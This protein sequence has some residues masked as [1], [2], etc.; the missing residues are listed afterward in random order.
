MNYKC[1][2][3]TNSLGNNE[4]FVVCEMMFGMRESFT[5]FRCSSCGCLQIIEPPKD[6]SKFYPSENYYSLQT[7]QDTHHKTTVKNL[8]KQYLI[9]LYLTPTGTFLLK[10]VPYI[11]GIEGSGKH[12]N[13]VK[14][15]RQLKK[16]SPIL[17]V[18][19]GVGILLQE[20]SFWGFKNL[21]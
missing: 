13:V 16:T 19:C 21:T 14:L 15:L 7:Q 12:R 10:K 8:I 6:I 18:G 1:K 11:R 2:I 5:Y 4:I 17:D 9:N 3:C 20:M